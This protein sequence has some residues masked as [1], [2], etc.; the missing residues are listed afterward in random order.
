MMP[1]GRA[2]IRARTEAGSTAKRGRVVKKPET[3]ASESKP[4]PDASNKKKPATGAVIESHPVGTGDAAGAAKVPAMPKVESKLV[5]SGTG[6][7]A[8]ALKSA[9]AADSAAASVTSKPTEKPAAKPSDAAAKPAATPAQTSVSTPTS[10]PA[11][12]ETRVIEVRKAGFM[13]T[14]LG[15]IIAAGLGAGATYWAIPKLPPAW[16]PG[17]GQG[18]QQGSLDEVRAVAT[19]VA[20]AEIQT[21]LDAVSGRAADAGADAARQLLADSG[22]SGASVA[23]AEALQAQQEKLAALERTVADLAARPAVPAVAP[24]DADGQLQALLSDMNARMTEQQRQI[25]R[26]SCRERVSSPV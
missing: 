3:D 1:F 16:Q 23:D 6:P 20:R 19:E 15:G 5:G 18:D 11:K 26:A 8:A 22:P 10:T 17:A 13:P 12:S 21:Q 25:G 14:L 9:A 4:A 24:G 2:P 7:A